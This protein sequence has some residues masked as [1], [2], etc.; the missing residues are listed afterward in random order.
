VLDQLAVQRPWQAGMALGVLARNWTEVVGERLAR[1]S[2]PAGLESGVLLV[3]ASSQGWA[4]QIRFLAEDVRKRS[5]AVTG[6][7]TVKGVRVYVRGP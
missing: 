6:E 1:E 3:R 5:E 4:A 2:S 7:G